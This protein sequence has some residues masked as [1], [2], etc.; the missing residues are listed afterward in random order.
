MISTFKS[1]SI[2]V[3]VLCAWESN[4]SREMCLS[5]RPKRKILI[6]DVSTQNA[7]QKCTTNIQGA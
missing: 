3:C 4:R 1:M 5:E 6:L 7:K 2:C